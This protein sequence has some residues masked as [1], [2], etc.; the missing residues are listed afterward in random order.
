MTVSLF[1]PCLVDQMAPEVAMA[2]VALLSRLGVPVAYPPAQTCCGQFAYT[3]G[4]VATARKLMRHFFRAFSGAGPIV[5]PS[6]SC[7]LM[8]RRHYPELAEGAEELRMAHSF[9][10]RTLELSEFLWQVGPLPWQPRLVA[11]LT[12]HHSCKARQLGLLA[13][14]PRLLNQVAGLNLL[15]P[16]PYY[17][18]CGFGGVFRWQHRDLSAVIGTAYLHA[19]AASG[20]AG[21][22]SLDLGCILHLR[23]LAAGLGLPLKF[24]HLA[25]VLLP[26][27]TQRAGDR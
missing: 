14:V 12:L 19:L 17:S 21:L 10:A 5:C 6:A 8:V 7:A 23:S 24:L 4:E 25:E 15:S 27:E 26:S 13:M 3:V 16:P 2:T 1:I 18:C 11:T 22:I 9:A 20:T